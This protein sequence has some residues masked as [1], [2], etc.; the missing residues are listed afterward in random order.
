MKKGKL[1]ISRIRYSR[2]APKILQ[3]LGHEKY[4]GQRTPSMAEVEPYWQSLWGE[5]VQNN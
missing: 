5:K 1:N 4:R 2:K 3:K